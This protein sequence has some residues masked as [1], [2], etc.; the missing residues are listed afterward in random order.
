MDIRGDKSMRQK[1]FLI[2]KKLGES[3]SKI[4][5]AWYNQINALRNNAD[6]NLMYT[7]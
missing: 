7:S 4:I 5:F 1:D 6:K 3:Q 2:E